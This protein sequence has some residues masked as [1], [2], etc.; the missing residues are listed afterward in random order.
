MNDEHRLAGIAR[1]YDRFA[2]RKDMS[3]RRLGQHR[4]FVRGERCK[5]VDSREPFGNRATVTI[6]NFRATTPLN[7]KR[8]R[9]ESEVQPST[10]EGIPDSLPHESIGIVVLRVVFK[11]VLHF[12]IDAVLPEISDTDDR[13]DLIGNVVGL[14]HSLA[15]DV[16]RFCGRVGIKRVEED[17]ARVKVV[18]RANLNR[19]LRGV[20]IGNQDDV[21]LKRAN[22]DCAPTDLFDHARVTLR[23]YSNDVAHLKRAIRL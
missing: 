10:T 7:M 23:A 19:L 14:T 6:T 17:D 20:T 4:R 3:H 15:H 9:R 11:P 12:I 18:A 13:R 16:D 22:L 21:I 1:T 2:G 8:S 5:D